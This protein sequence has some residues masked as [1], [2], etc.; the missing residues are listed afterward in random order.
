MSIATLQ[1]LETWAANAGFSSSTKV[2]GTPGYSQR[3]VIV[4]IAQAESGG[5]TAAVNTHDPNGGSFGILQINGFW[6]SHG[7]TKAGALDPQHAFNFAFT[8]IS[9]HG[10]N[11]SDWS[12]FQSGAY[13]KHI[14]QAA[15]S[16]RGIIHLPT[17]GWWNYTING[18]LGDP[19]PFGGFKHDANIFGL[20][21]NYPIATI[22]SGT[23]TAIDN[24]HDPYGGTV[25]IK[26]DNPINSLATHLAFLHLSQINTAIGKHVVPG[27]IVAHAGSR[28][29]GS[30]NASL[31]VALYTGD[32]YG[33]GTEWNKITKSQVQ[34]PLNVVPIIEAA[35]NGTLTEGGSSGI[36]GGASG[37][38]TTTNSIG[39]AISVTLGNLFDI[40]INQQ[41]LTD[42][43]AK[44]KQNNPLSP[45][46]SI[47]AVC[48]TLDQMMQYENPFNAF[49]SGNLLSDIGTFL[50]AL[51]VIDFPS[52]L[53][54]S[55]FLL[56]GIYIIFKVVNAY[57]N[58]TGVVGSV[59]QLAGTAAAFA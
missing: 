9:H 58:I 10:T 11:F 3:D 35:K 27:D 18:N 15:S 46:L 34:G 57:I 56:F 25:T 38:S 28:P 13:E 7:I 33:H 20:P 39:G 37:S 55:F 48:I 40:Q 29:L 26:L 45:D 30:E 52:L 12:T 19:D 14:K 47:A 24:G 22:L 44:V 4:A 50:Q 49:G 2:A 16:Q 53:L 59:I 8:N 43:L 42:S 23:V 6:F 31:G 54:R 1:Q 17:N 41:F 5:N 21:A 36:T 51:F 32:Q